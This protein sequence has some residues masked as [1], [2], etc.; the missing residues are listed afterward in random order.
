MAWL[1]RQKDLRPE[2][3]KQE[4][5]Q[6]FVR[7]HADVLDHAVDVSL[8]EVPLDDVSIQRLKDSNY[9]ERGP[10]VACG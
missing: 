3:L 2:D 4:E 7:K 5:V 8:R 1:W 6:Q 9:A 10:A